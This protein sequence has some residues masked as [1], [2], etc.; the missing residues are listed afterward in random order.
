MK[1]EDANSANSVEGIL[2]D[3]GRHDGTNDDII[4]VVPIVLDAN[5]SNN[6]D[7]SSSQKASFPPAEALKAAGEFAGKAADFARDAVGAAK[8]TASKGAKKAGDIAADLAKNAPPA[9]ASVAE[10]VQ[11]GIADM[12]DKA[13]DTAGS[14]SEKAQLAKYNPVS[15]E[16]TFLNE[17]YT[18]PQMIVIAD[19]SERENIEVCRNAIGWKDTA[20]GMGVLYLYKQDAPNTEL[21]FLPQ[22]LEDAVYYED[23][24]NPGRYISLDSYFDTIQKD[25]FTELQD[26]AFC[27]GAKKCVLESEEMSKS[28]RRAKTKSSA[29]AKATKTK[30]EASVQ[31]EAENHSKRHVEFAQE[32]EGSDEP[33]RPELKWFAND[34]Q[35]EHL[36][37]TRC[38]GSNKI[39]HYTMTLDE[40]ASQAISAQAAA[41]VEKALKKIGVSFNF[42]FEGEALNESR[43]KLFFE[44]EF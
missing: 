44:I 39:T 2:G 34:R 3:E 38:S 10:K 26:I 4:D 28:L 37:N 13:R 23:P 14:V 43:R 36:I 33:R 40:T 41:K 1:A 35:I 11:S 16:D 5:E 42:S 27:L 6:G 24:T 9:A 7:S 12:A 20:G 19:S 22:M 31:V 8:D 21:V 17:N 25:K 30:G 18:P 32:F 29:N 15:W